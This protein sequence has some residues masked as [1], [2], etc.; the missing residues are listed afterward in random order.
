MPKPAFRHLWVFFSKYWTDWQCALVVVKP[1]TVLNWHRTA[2]RLYWAKKS[3]PLGRPTV[4]RAAIALIKRIHRE[5]PLW[6]PERIHDQMFSLGVLDIPC[7]NTIAKYIP[8]LRKPPSERSQQ[9]WKT[10][11][12]NHMH[13]TWSMDFFTMPTI[14]FRMLYVFVVIN[15]ARR[16]IM[17]I[18]V[19]K[20]PTMAW[21]VQQL[22]EAMPFGEQPRFLI[23][24]NDS[25]YGKDVVNFLDAIG[26]QVVHTTYKSSWQNPFVERF[27]GILRRE[28]LDHIIPLDERHL[29]RATQGVC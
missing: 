4:S 5:N 21:T 19:T 17:H 11:I 22:R 12:S 25:I 1:Q 28:L 7:P 18:A 3:K 27:I 8:I 15:H 13:D 6:S 29:E 2:F 16:Q 10:L 23:R 26:V 24:D 14:T 20:H 9:S